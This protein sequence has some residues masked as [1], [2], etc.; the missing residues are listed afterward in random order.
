MEDLGRGWRRREAEL[1]DPGGRGLEVE[2]G[3]GIQIE[4]ETWSFSRFSPGRRISPATDCILMLPGLY[5][6]PAFTIRFS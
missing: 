3:G 2:E 6:Q 1:L 4:G 5:Q